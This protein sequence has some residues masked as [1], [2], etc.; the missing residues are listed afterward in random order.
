MTEKEIVEEL[1][2][3]RSLLET[4]PSEAEGL[5][6]EFKDFLSQYKVMGLAVAFI[7]GIYL[8]NLVQALVNDI[9]MPVIGLTVP[10]LENMATLQWTIHQQTFLIGDFV[11][12]L[13]IFVIIA[14]VI[15]VLVKITKRWGIE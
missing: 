13:I 11:S 15:F 14:A 4:H 3:I 7:M 6:D 1:R 2:K 10:G 12:A 9:I 5:W 8:G